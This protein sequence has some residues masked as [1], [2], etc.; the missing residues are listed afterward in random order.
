MGEAFD[1]PQTS[2]KIRPPAGR[3][4]S[5]RGRSVGWY[6]FESQTRKQLRIPMLFLNPS[7]GGGGGLAGREKVK[8]LFRPSCW[9]SAQWETQL[10]ALAYHYFPCPHVAMLCLAVTDRDPGPSKSRPFFS[11]YYP[12]PGNFQEQTGINRDHF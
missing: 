12:G 6:I 1:Y 9:R 8:R 3:A 11:D 7:G 5:W 2:H 10:L 4:S